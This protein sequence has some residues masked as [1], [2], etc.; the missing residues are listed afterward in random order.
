M[1]ATR[2]DTD[3]LTT[4]LADLNA[5]G[6]GGWSLSGGQLCKTF[7]FPDFVRAFGFM[8][9]VALIAESMNHHPDWSNVY[10][11]VRVALSTHETGGITERDIELARQMEPLVA[12]AETH[13][14][15]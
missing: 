14:T 8:T 13:V 5:L 10:G 15:Q 9:Q 12:T 2:L 11:Q 6:Q 7:V 3:T 1:S 4:A